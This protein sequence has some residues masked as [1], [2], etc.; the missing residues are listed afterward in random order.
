MTGEIFSAESFLWSC[1]WQSTI[2]LTAGL[3]G[4]FL[5]RRHSARAHRVLFLA[6]IAA[7][8]VPAASI[9]VKQYELG[10]FVAEPVAVQ[11]QTEDRVIYETT[12]IVANEP[13]ERRPNPINED[14][15]SAAAVSKASKFPWRSAL[16]YAWIAASLILAAR[17]LVTFVLG[18]RLL[19][20][21]RPLNN[22]KIEQAIGLAK[23]KLGINKDVKIYGSANIH[24]PVIW[25]WKRRP[26]LLIPSAADRFD[27]GIDW[28]GVLCHELA[29]YKRRDHVAGLLA[30]LTVCLLPWHPLLWW[31]KSHLISLSEQACDDWVVAS[32]RPGTDYAESL[33]NLIPVEQMA[34]VP[35]VVSNKRGLAGRIRRILKDNCGNPRTGMKWALAVSVVAIC[36]TV[37]VALAQTRPDRSKGR[38]VHFPGDSSVGQ[39]SV[40]D[41][42]RVRRITH[43]F[44]WGDPTEWE[45][46]G[47]AQGDVHVPAGKRLCLILNKPAWRN[48]SWLSKLRP[49]DIYALIIP[50]SSTDPVKPSDRCMPYI[51]NLAGLRS[52]NIGMTDVTDKGLRYIRNLKSLEYLDTPPRM[53]DSGMA[54]IAE[55]TSL[56]GL[57]LGGVGI[58][59]ITN[60]GLRHISK[61]TSLKELY[62]RGER[63][64]DAGL[65]CLRALPRLDYLCLYGSHFTD[66]GLVHVKAVP[67]LRILSFHENLCRITDAGM[68]QIA[69]MP[70]LQLLCMHAISNITD[71][72][73][74]NLSKSR[75]L[76]K[77][78][79][80]GSQVTDKGLGHL[81]RIKTLEC[82]NLPQKQKGITD[83]G[84]AHLGRL[85]NLKNLGIARMHYNNPKMNKE[86]YTD[87]GLAELANCRLLEALSIGS[88]GITDSGIE[89]IAKL[90][91]LKGLTM[92]GCDNVTDAG[93][94]KLAALKSLK[95]LKVTDADISIKGLNN[96][97][98]MPNLTNLSISDLKRKGAILDMS[99][100]TAMER[101]DLSFRSY[102]EKFVDADLKSLANLKQLKWLTIGPRD[103]SDKGMAYL[104]GLTNLES[105][106]IGGAGLTDEGLKYLANMKKLDR[107]CI[108]TGFDASKRDFGSG[109]DITDKGL[110]YLKELKQLHLLDIYSDNSFSNTALRR[111]QRDLPNLFILK[112]NGGMLLKINS[113]DR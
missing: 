58:S 47:Q 87:K 39:L 54:Y 10:V 79:I 6:I 80:S 62:L 28:A 98:K 36:L 107:L 29:H 99:G 97:K 4:S 32:G 71:Y 94:A 33:L 57:Y 96:L 61:L 18:G 93:L 52:L 38:I 9:L 55:L 42:S 69:E 7:V 37:G 59:Q 19:R 88:I 15:H 1:L 91:N 110:G 12:G 89:H 64:G 43:W 14:L 34:F 16:I 81:S 74:A 21:A 92:Y 63:M 3:L 24:S 84:L 13:I 77:L 72:G 11:P 25:C 5:L 56:K 30:E 85:P 68:T 106:S 105:L 112:I 35:A 23:L 40:Q 17:L 41:A 101:L 95:K 20:R 100:L 51:A 73:L 82:L 67:S 49:D 2:F 48:W 76:K 46:L 90:N 108:F 22:D 111:L 113:K 53:T 26:V 50:A 65:A 66:R 45:Y 83:K 75:S 27:N 109:G 86:Y 44:H 31:A 8:I 102:S 70:K 103:Y 78:D 60:A 104:A